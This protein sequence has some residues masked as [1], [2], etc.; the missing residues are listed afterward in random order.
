LTDDILNCTS[1]HFRRSKLKRHFTV[2]FVSLLLQSRTL[3]KVAKTT[4]N[5]QKVDHDWSQKCLRFGGF[6]VDVDCLESLLCFELELELEKIIII[7]MFVFFSP[8]RA[9][10]RQPPTANAAESAK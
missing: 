1:N 10:T 6:D 5:T 9:P 2:R 8:F 3:L 4:T 7:I